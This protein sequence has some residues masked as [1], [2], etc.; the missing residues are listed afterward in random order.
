MMIKLSRG[1]AP[2]QI[3]T[4]RWCGVKR[5]ERICKECNSGEVED[6]CHWL[7]RCEAWY[8]PE[9]QALLQSVENGAQEMMDEHKTATILS[10]A[11]SNYRTYPIQ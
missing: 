1:T 9:H 3:E 5:K 11:C 10:G 8:G 7:E 6:E 4:R 2:F